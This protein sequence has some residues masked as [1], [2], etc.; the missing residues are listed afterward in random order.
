MTKIGVG[1]GE[2]FPIEDRSG[3]AAASG[4]TAAPE[5]E[6]AHQNPG[7]GPHEAGYG[8][9]GWSRY[10]GESE[11]DWHA[12]RDAWRRQRYEWRQQRREWRRRYREQMRM[13]HGPG[14][15]LYYYWGLP[16]VLRIV[17]IVAAIMLV[18]RIVAAAPL[19]I[20]GAAVL[21]VL[22]A[23][24]RHYGP[25]HDRDYAPPSAGSNGA[26]PAQGN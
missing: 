24:H 17:L 12:R 2:D 1:I 13:R 6:G 18:F 20:L 10:A 11:E 16:R 5:G 23:A 9:C 21:G 19:I 14:D 26:P 7:E 15:P 3:A 25:F 8:P 22:Y 4:G